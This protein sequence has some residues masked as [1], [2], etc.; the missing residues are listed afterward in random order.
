MMFKLK[1]TFW[2]SDSRQAAK[3][4]S[5]PTSH[6]KHYLEVRR[7]AL[8]GSG[9]KAARR[10]LETDKPLGDRSQFQIGLHAAHGEAV[11]NRIETAVTDVAEV[12]EELADL[13]REEEWR[14]ADIEKAD[15]EIKEAIASREKIPKPRR[16]LA[17]ISTGAYFL[18]MGLFAGCEY[19]LLRL[20]FVRLPVDDQTIK[21]I[22][23]L[24]GATLV[25]GVHVLAL[26]ASRLV[27][28]EGD[29]IESRRD[30]SAH[31]AVVAFGVGFY[32][33][34]I[35][36]LAWVRAGEINGI[37]KTFTG[38]GMS[39]PIWLGVALGALHAATLLAAF[40]VAY[41]R[42]RGAEYRDAKILIEK[43]QADKKAAEQ[44]LED[45]DRREARL[46]V[47]REG[48]VDRADRDLEQLHRHHRLEESSYLAILSRSFDKPPKSIDDWDNSRTPRGPRTPSTRSLK[49]P[50]P[51]NGKP[52]AHTTERIRRTVHKP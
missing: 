46:Q 41:H 11:H 40:Y 47:R 8:G 7:E 16:F 23:I 29:R 17:S 39:H 19:P 20:S 2:D 30:W 27:Q 21:V 44:A 32:A 52:D 49:K 9:E 12:D 5:G 24:T 31:R 3:T 34:V 45:L 26:A 18:I 37:D 36:G 10:D 43:R 35:T 50:A 13:E 42:A 15:N 38:H 25:A 48:I 22:A 1:R 33:F 51:K 14:S 4:P 28:A 6:A